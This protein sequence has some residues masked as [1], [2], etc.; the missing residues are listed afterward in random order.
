[1]TTVRACLA[2]ALVLLFP[3]FSRAENA[4]VGII[5]D[6]NGPTETVFVVRG[7]R[8]LHPEVG[9]L[10]LSGDRITVANTGVTVTVNLLSRPEPLVINKEN[11]PELGRMLDKTSQATLVGNVLQWLVESLPKER[12]PQFVNMAIRG[13]PSAITIPVF[14]FGKQTV[15]AG[16]RD[17]QLTWQGGGA[18]YELHLS[19]TTS[20]RRVVQKKDLSQASVV[21]EGVNLSVGYYAIEVQGGGRKTTQELTVVAKSELPPMPREIQGLK[22][23]EK[24][25]E[26]LYITWLSGHEGGK[27]A[28]EAM[29]QAYKAS[30][31]YPPAG[32]LLRSLS[33]GVVATSPVK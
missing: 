11:A 9:F 20:S 2:V 3:L 18:P 14:K 10:V 28:L 19:N 21:L 25:R 23:A 6:I 24:F 17:W 16:S 29:L 12:K 8:S 32:R 5:A 33:E 4:P 31:S 1:M 15:I 22:T 26:F 27:W 30:C 13:M 7:Q